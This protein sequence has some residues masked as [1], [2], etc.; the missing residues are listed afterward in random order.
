MKYTW[1]DGI[2][3]EVEGCHYCPFYSFD[4]D[5]ERSVCSYP[6]KPSEILSHVFDWYSVKVMG[7]PKDCPLRESI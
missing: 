5:D 3:V 7:M 4:G 2:Y 6:H 1:I